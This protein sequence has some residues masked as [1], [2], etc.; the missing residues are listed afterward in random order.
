MAHH[1]AIERRSFHD[2]QYLAGHSS[3]TTRIYRG[4]RRLTR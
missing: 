3:P 4:R 1:E 2:L